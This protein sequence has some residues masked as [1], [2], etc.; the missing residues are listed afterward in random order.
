ML[1]LEQI[2]KV[3]DKNNAWVWSLEVKPAG[4]KAV[5]IGSYEPDEP[6]KTASEAMLRQTIADLPGQ[7]LQITPKRAVKSHGAGVLGPFQFTG[8]TAGPVQGLSGLPG[9]MPSTPFEMYMQSMGGIGGFIPRGV[10]DQERALA[11]RE[12]QV[13]IKEAMLERDRKDFEERKK[14]ILADLKAKEERADSRSEQV[15]RGVGKVLGDAFD[16]WSE[17]PSKQISGTQESQEQTPADVAI[18]AL[19]THIYE[20]L[21]DVED[22]N[23]VS[24]MAVSFVAALPVLKEKGRLANAE[25]SIAKILTTLQQ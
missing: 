15:A 20:N 22:V 4:G 5:P 6:E 19:A 14:E 13:A 16:T 7:V 12:M 10:A 1:T 23:S 11:S 17:K 3:M 8:P 24:R 21:E 25:T 18:E 2:L 9:Q